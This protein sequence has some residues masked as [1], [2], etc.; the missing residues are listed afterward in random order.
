MYSRLYLCPPIDLDCPNCVSPAG[1]RCIV[2][3]YLPLYLL[4]STTLLILALDVVSRY[5]CLSVGC[6]VLGYI[7]CIL[8]STTSTQTTILALNVLSNMYA[9]IVSLNS[10]L[11]CYSCHILL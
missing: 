9:T 7:A 4:P 11:T 3:S 5:S 1:M 2:N 10:V 8:R 6:V